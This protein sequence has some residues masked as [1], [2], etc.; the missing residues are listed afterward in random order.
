VRPMQE[1]VPAHGLLRRYLAR[2]AGF[3]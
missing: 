3:T 2:R 1:L